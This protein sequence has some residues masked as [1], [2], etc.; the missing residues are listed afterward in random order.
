MSAIKSQMELKRCTYDSTLSLG[1]KLRE[2][3]KTGQV[4]SVKDAMSDLEMTWSDFELA[5]KD[6]SE[7]VNGGL[8]RVKSET[9]IKPEWLVHWENPDVCFTRR[10]KK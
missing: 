4:T 10:I 8:N 9:S 6:C 2:N 5:L 1:K 3:P 7:Q